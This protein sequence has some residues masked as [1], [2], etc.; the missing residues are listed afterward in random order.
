MHCAERVSALRLKRRLRRRARNLLSPLAA[1][2]PRG[3][4][5]HLRSVDP[6]DKAGGRHAH[7]SEQR[8]HDR[9]GVEKLGLALVALEN[10]RAAAHEEAGE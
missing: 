3:R 10:L 9:V 6:D 7:R 5:H 1:A 2:R 8:A 4:G